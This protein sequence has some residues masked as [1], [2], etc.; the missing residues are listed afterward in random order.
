MRVLIHASVALLITLTASISQGLEKPKYQVVFESGKIE[1][2]IYDS[3]LVAETTVPFASSYR[4]ASNEGFFR[5]FDYISGDNVS[6]AS[7][8]M[9][10]PV[11]QSAEKISMTAPVQQQKNDQGWTV[12]FM[13]PSKY[14]LLSV[15]TPTSEKIR[16]REV[17]ER[18]MAVIRYSGRWTEKN[19]D[20]YANKL[21][22]DIEERG[23]EPVSEPESA[24]YN[25]PFVPPFMRRNEA[26]I[27]VS[28]YPSS[29]SS[30]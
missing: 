7:I 27:E 29:N 9:T 22:L 8:A 11:Q 4:K 19:F 25:P 16:I 28:R 1:Y 23:I 10:S 12:A 17:P 14:D 30:Q 20:K 13:V 3:Y 6:G 24:V 18:I 26:M 5:L 21:K 15:P 2:R